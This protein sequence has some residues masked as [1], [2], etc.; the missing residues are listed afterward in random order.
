MSDQETPKW[1][2]P[3]ALGA[4]LLAVIDSF[5]LTHLHTLR[6]TK[7]LQSSLC[8]LSDVA[9]CQITIESKYSELAGI[10]ISNL[11]AVTYGLIAAVALL[12]LMEAKKAFPRLLLLGG[13]FTTLVSLVMAVISYGILKTVCPA[14][15]LLYV[16]SGVLLFAGIKAVK[17]DSSGETVA[18]EM[19][20]FFAAKPLGLSAGITAS[21]L[22]VIAGVGKTMTPAEAVTQK[23][24]R[25]GQDEHTGQD[26]GPDGEHTGAEGTEP[27]PEQASAIVAKFMEQM[28]QVEM[29]CGP[30]EPKGNPQAKVTLYEFADFQCPACK[31]FV[32]TMKAL[33]ETHSDKM[34]VC[35]RNYPLDGDCNPRI[36]KGRGHEGSCEAAAAAVCASQ[37]GK[38][39]DFYYAMFDM[40][41]PGL[42][43]RSLHGLAKDKGLDVDAFDKCV[44]SDAVKQILQTD[45]DK[46]AQIGLEG[47]PTLVINDRRL[48]QRPDARLLRLIIDNEHK[49][50]GGQ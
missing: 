11:S 49:K 27:T 23:D 40:Q 5:Y 2:Y 39:W 41:G 44:K 7:E 36:P 25:T 37:Q 28:P 18:D 29:D 33:L 48:R 10:P 38:M 42:N 3:A 4:S 24:T 6:H 19:G 8:T 1:I 26:H 21:V 47:T 12:G 30:L 35:F 22:L 20:R 32:P 14:C 17:A 16:L 43:E 45:M 34:R 15:T 31:A 50:A 9:N 13:A 46:G